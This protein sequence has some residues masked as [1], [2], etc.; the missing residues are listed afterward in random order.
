MG[1]QLREST[2]PEVVPRLVAV[3]DPTAGYASELAKNPKGAGSIS[4]GQSRCLVQVTDLI[5]PAAN[6]VASVGMETSEALAARPYLPGS[7]RKFPS[8]KSKA[9]RRLY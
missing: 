4:R 1:D 3:V 6:A 7:V 8:A 5:D 2:K 9:N